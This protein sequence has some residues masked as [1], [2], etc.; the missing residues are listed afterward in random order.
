[1]APR[2]KKAARAAPPPRAPRRATDAGFNQASLA[3]LIGVTVESIRLWTQQGCPRRDDGSYICAEVVAWLRQ[4]ER[5]KI[6]EE[7][8]TSGKAPT[9]MN[10]K[11]AAEAD[12]KELQLARERGETL[13]AEVFDERMGRVVGGFAAVAKGQ[14]HRYERAIV[15]TTTAVEARKLTEQI[16][17]ALMEGAHNLADELDTEAATLATTESAA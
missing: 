2:A 9:E 11:L 13:T 3:R 7:L 17:A 16:H 10:R 12:L 1:M 5:E 4:R 6:R 15:R 8:K 14:L